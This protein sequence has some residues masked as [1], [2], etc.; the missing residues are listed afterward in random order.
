V[1]SP[2][3]FLPLAL[4]HLCHPPIAS[5]LTIP[6]CAR[7]LLRS[8]LADH[9]YTTDGKIKEPNLLAESSDEL[10][11]AGM[12]L[13]TGNT[14]G[15]MSSLFGVAKGAFNANQSNEKTKTTRTSPADVVMWSGCKDD[16]TVSIFPRGF[17]AISSTIPSLVLQPCPSFSAIV[18]C[19]LLIDWSFTDPPE[20]R[21]AGRRRSDRSHVVRVHLVIEKGPEAEL[22]AAPSERK[23]GDEG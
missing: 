20:R 5:K 10:M 11:S 17:P 14:A 3:L 4:L 6:P 15:A 1:S 13:L 22:P 18:S 23:G 19:C 7:T 21:H 9:Q 8:L 12:S 16:Q 2:S